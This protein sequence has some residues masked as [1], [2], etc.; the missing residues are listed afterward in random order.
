MVSDSTRALASSHR[1]HD[2]GGD[3][4]HALPHKLRNLPFPYGGAIYPVHRA[5][6]DPVFL[7]CDA[8]FAHSAR[9][10]YAAPHRSYDS[11]GVPATMGSP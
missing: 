9:V 8:D 2:H 6:T 4:I 10:R 5:R 3:I 1:L 7:F 11:A